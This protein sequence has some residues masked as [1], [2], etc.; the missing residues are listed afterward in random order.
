MSDAPYFNPKPDNKDHAFPRFYTRAVENAFKSEAEGHPCFDD[1]DYV[2]I[3][4]GGDTRTTVDRAVKP[5]DKERWPEHWRRYREGQEAP[6]EGVPLMEW[7]QITASVIKELNAL[8]FRTVEQLAGASDAALQRFMG[9][10]ALREKAR[11]W[12][13]QANDQAAS[14]K[15]AQEKA[16]LQAQINALQNQVQ[17]LAAATTKKSKAHSEAA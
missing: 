8:N 10:Q 2:E 15:W 13:E 17:E 6:T 9:G 5:E 16:D 11:L 12:L 14:S 7:P 3:T 4:I 1:V